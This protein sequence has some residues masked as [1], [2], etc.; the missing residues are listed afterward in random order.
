MDSLLFG[1]SRYLYMPFYFLSPKIPYSWEALWVEFGD[2]GTF[3]G[4]EAV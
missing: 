2:L 3:Y 1:G 4:R